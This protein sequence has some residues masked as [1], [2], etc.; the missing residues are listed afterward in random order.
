MFKKEA[1]G[2]FQEAKPEYNKAL[3]L[4]TGSQPL[5]G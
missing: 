2:N 5:K 1:A 4:L 3:K